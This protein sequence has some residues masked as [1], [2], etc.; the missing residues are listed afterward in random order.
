MI[1]MHWFAIETNA[2]WK[3]CLTDKRTSKQ[4]NELGFSRLSENVIFY[5]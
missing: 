4:A 1:E 2:F 3:V 5:I